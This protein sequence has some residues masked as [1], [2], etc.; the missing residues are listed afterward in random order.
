MAESSDV[1][2]EFVQAAQSVIGEVV[3]VQQSATTQYN[4]EATRDT[5]RHY[6]WGTTDLNPLWVNE[7]YA[8][9]S[10]FGTIVA[11]PTFP[12]SVVLPT[13]PVYNIP[14]KK[15]IDFTVVFGGTTWDFHRPIFCGDRLHATGRLTKAEIK[16]SKTVGRMVSLTPETL[17]FNQRNELVA[18]GVSKQLR[19]LPQQSD[20]RKTSE[21][22]GRKKDEATPKE[23][24]PEALAEQA[25]RRGSSPL[26]WEDVKEG[27]SLP[28]VPKGT[29]RTT[30]II[31]WI[32][33][34][35]G[36][37]FLSSRVA[38]SGEYHGAGH[39]NSELAQSG[40][41]PGAYDNGPLRAGWLSQ[42]ITNWM[43]DWGD[44]VRLEYS[45][46]FF[47][48]VG[49]VSTAKGK[50]ARKRMVGDDG[51][52]D[53]EVAVENHRGLQSAQGVATVRLPVRG[54]NIAKAQ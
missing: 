50:V 49:D 2:D 30:D 46:R 1:L 31:R 38:A 22:Q 19:F 5:I 29:L 34:T 39:Y 42:L 41:I 33:G 20:A 28:D 8:R 35:Y 52:V 3:T 37:P 43:G 17:Y 25:K 27:E 4:E 16:A 24:S 18:R 54:V 12:Y 7:E 26:Y 51:L 9:R 13:L 32:A 47:N 40:G 36:P 6:A 48:V 44:L 45:L 53:L 14:F 23:I 21:L 15:K 11:A 10:R